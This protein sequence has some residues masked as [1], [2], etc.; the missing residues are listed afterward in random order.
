VLTLNEAYQL[1]QVIY[2][3]PILTLLRH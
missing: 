1:A 2:V 3:E